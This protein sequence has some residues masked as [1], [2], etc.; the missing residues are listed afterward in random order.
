MKLLLFLGTALTLVHSGH[1]IPDFCRLPKDEGQGT[2]FVYSVHYDQAT[3]LCQPFLYRGQGGNQNR[4]SNERECMRNC[5]VN[6]DTIYPM[7]WTKA[8]HFPKAEGKCSGTL[9][10]YYYDSVHDKCKKFLYTGCF[11][12]GNRFTDSNI[13][14]ATCNG[15]HGVCTSLY[16]PH[17][18]NPY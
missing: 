5:S 11:G 3:D 15:I 18:Q 10:R 16:Y 1:L 8:C 12:N 9:L 7:D 4:F 14:N 2:S 13:C 17:T 6:F